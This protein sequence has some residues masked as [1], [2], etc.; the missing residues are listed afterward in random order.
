MVA[1]LPLLLA[2]ARAPAPDPALHKIDVRIA[3]PLA[4]VEVWRAIE[5]NTSNVRGKQ[6]GTYLDINLPAGATLL[7]WELVERGGATRLLPR[8]EV[9]AN[10]GLAAALKMRHLSLPPAPPD[11]GTGFRK[12]GTSSRPFLVLWR[13]HCSCR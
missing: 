5:A 12:R 9:E 3:G 2:L 13:L 7:D 10:T 6:V 1:W 8:T 11:E 4:M